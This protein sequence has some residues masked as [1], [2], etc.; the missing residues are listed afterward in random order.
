LLHG[1]HWLKIK[2]CRES[3][4]LEE[5]ERGI[6]HTL[7]GYAAEGWNRSPSKNQA[8]YGVLMIE[9]ARS[10]GIVLIP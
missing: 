3:G 8:K 9:K 1:D 10:T 2:K 6:A 5:W 4:E 7:A